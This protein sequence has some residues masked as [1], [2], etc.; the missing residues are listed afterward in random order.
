MVRGV[1]YGFGV[2]Y[3]RGGEDSFVRDVGV[4]IEGFVLEYGIILC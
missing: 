1:G 4:G 2:V 3:E